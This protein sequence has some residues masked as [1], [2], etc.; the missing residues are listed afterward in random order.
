MFLSGGL[1]AR[2]GFG[3]RDL[4]L[5]AVQQT[6]RVLDDEPP[7]AGVLEKGA[8]DFDAEAGAAFRTD[9]ENE[10]VQSA[11]LVGR[12]W[13]RDEVFGFRVVDHF[14]PPF[15][16]LTRSTASRSSSFGSRRV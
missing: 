15:V 16:F 1:V 11:L 2:G 10:G 12:A 4:L 14:A 7:E 9:V 13:L 8:V 6:A 5:D 3:L